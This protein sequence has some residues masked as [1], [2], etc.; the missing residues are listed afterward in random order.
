MYEIK[1]DTAGG[2][3]AHARNYMISC[4]AI[5]YDIVSLA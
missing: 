5:A 2:G 3:T 4:H 1:L